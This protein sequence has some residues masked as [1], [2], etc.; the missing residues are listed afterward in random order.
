M[1]SYPEHVQKLIDELREKRSIVIREATPLAGAM[2]NNQLYRLITEDGESFVAKFYFQDDRKR[3]EREYPFLA[4]LADHDFKDVPHPLYESVTLDCGVYQWKEGAR[5][6]PERY[7][8]QD[9]QNLA[10]FIARIHRLDTSKGAHLLDAQ[11]AAFS[12]KDLRA[13]IEKRLEWIREDLAKQLFHEDVVAFLETHRSLERVQE[14]LDA[15]KAAYG[16]E[17]FTYVFPEHHKRISSVDFGP[18]NTLFQTDGSPVYL[19]FENAG[20]DHPLRTV[21]DVINHQKLETVP[22]ALKRIFVDHYRAQAHLPDDV[23]HWFEPIRRCGLIEWHLLHLTHLRPTKIAQFKFSLANEAF[24][25]QKFIQEKLR[26]A[27]QTLEAMIG[28]TD[29]F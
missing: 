20:M 4:L 2:N 6:S 10:D 3:R 13:N 7:T 5:T 21:V 8:E 26:L 16:E 19:D 23:W 15:M 25:E 28:A 29:W 9:M 1:S 18:H 14:A 27:K 24:D 22:L 17:V 11:M 12:M